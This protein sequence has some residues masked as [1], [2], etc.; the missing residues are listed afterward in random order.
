MW[1]L[2]FGQHEDRTPKHGYGLVGVGGSTAVLII[3]SG[4]LYIRFG[5][6]GFWVM[7]L[8]CIAAFPVICTLHRELSRRAPRPPISRFWRP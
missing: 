5:S 1:T 8:L 6:A 3:L 7:A 2:A 4:W